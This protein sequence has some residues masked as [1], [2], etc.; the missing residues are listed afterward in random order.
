MTE[1]LTINET[2][3][4]LKLSDRT[5]YEKLRRGRLPGAAKLG[6]EWRIDRDKLLDWIARGGD[7]GE[8]TTAAK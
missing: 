7:L 5:V 8:P 6:K 2:A 4:L 1:L 3:A